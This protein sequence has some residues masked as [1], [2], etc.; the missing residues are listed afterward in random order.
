LQYSS[1][2]SIIKRKEAIAECRKIVHCS[3]CSKVFL[4]SWLACLSVTKR[5][6]LHHSCA[7]SDSEYRS[8]SRNVATPFTDV[9]CAISIRMSGQFVAQK[10]KFAFYMFSVSPFNQGAGVVQSVL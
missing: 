6:R 2:F 8:F 5:G 1:E 10:D 9:V 3:R 7:G 4:L